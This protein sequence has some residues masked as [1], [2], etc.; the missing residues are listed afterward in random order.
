M[1]PR[2]SHSRLVRRRSS[3]SAALSS[4]RSLCI[5][6]SASVDVIIDL[7]GE[8]G[9]DGSTYVPADPTRLLDTRSVGP[10]G[11]VLAAARSAS[12][13]ASSRAA[14]SRGA[15]SSSCRSASSCR[16]SA[17]LA[18]PNSRRAAFVYLHG[19]ES[20]SGWFDL[21]AEQLAD[22]GYPVFSLDRR[23]SGLNRE[24]RGYISGHIDD[25]STLVDDVHRAVEI[26]K[27]AGKFSEIYL[28]GLSCRGKYAMPYDTVTSGAA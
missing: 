19:I 22:R 10:L 14:A 3:R 5:T 24:N 2:A 28:I 27:S 7:T 11:A 26:T 6:A 25:Q 17:A 21:A 23:G 8:F 12:A 9:P 15:A 16:C 20:H 4:T 13:T 1:T 18:T